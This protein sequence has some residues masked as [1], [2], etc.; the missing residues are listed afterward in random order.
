MIELIAEIVASILAVSISILAYFATSQKRKVKRLEEEID[1]LKWDI[2]KETS[3]VNPESGRRLVDNAEKVIRVFDI[4]ALSAFH[5]SREALIK[6]VEKSDS[7]LQII[8]IDPDSAEFA[9]REK[10]E[11]DTSSR[12]FTEWTASL[13]ILQ[14]LQSHSKGSVELYLLGVEPD[15]FLLISD[16]HDKLTRYS[17]ML[18]DY[19]PDT[20]R[21]YTG[22][23][24]LAEYVRK[25][26]HDSLEKNLD[27]FNSCIEKA[28]RVDVTDT[29]E[30]YVASGRKAA[31]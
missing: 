15:R 4:N 3:G 9:A 18:I 27:F 25:R 26:D 16:A 30:R 2:H 11:E 17:R 21:G 5:H 19:Y 28:L 22:N 24:F 14:D 7:L 12:I 23:Q 20:G 31:R 29:Y 10:K 13:A 6:F 1:Y 8:L